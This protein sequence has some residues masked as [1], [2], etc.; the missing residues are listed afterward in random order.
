MATQPLDKYIE[1]LMN[2]LY[3]GVPIRSTKTSVQRYIDNMSINPKYDINKTISIQLSKEK[4]GEQ[5]P[6]GL[7]SSDPGAKLDYGKPDLDLVLGDFNR[8]LVAVGQVGTFGAAKYS[9]SGWLEVP[10]SISR[11]SSALWRHFL[12]RYRG[13]MVDRDSNLLHLSHLAWN[14]LAILELTLRNQE[15]DETKTVNK[16]TEGTSKQG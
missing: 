14:S 2:Y 13:E 9:R 4:V 15:N 6:S 7:K 1:E 5:D 8:A 11:Y 3:C 12:A 10:N 16:F